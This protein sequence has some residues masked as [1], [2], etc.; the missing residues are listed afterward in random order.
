MTYKSISV[1][2]AKIK[3]LKTRSEQKAQVGQEQ[4]EHG[5]KIKENQLAKKQPTVSYLPV[6]ILQISFLWP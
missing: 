6:H 5:K 3:F 4:L 1:H 2:G